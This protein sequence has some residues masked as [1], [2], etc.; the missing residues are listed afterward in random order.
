VQDEID[1]SRKSR[2][3]ELLKILGKPAQKA[4][5]KEL[6]GLDMLPAN[7][8]EIIKKLDAELDKTDPLASAIK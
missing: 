6:T 1:D 3:K 8:E 5:I 4:L 7:Y 2:I